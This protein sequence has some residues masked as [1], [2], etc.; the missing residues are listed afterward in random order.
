[1]SISKL[2][3]HLTIIHD[4]MYHA[5]TALPCFESKSKSSNAFMWLSIAVTDMIAHGHGDVKFAH[6]SLHL[7][8]DDSNHTVNSVAKLLR[9]LEKPPASL[10]GVLFKNSRS[11]PLF[12]AILKRKEDCV[13]SL[14]TSLPL[15]PR[16]RL[17]PI[18]HVQLE[19]QQE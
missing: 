19:R 9:D 7:Y 10:S 16:R 8:P 4:K 1:M 3:K 14:G 11:T 18:L 6:F 17:P 2:E 15:I 5:K 13:A 12:E